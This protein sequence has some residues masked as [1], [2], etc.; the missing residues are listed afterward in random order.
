MEKAVLDRV[1]DGKHAVLL[2]GDDEREVMIPCHQLPPGAKK[3]TWFKVTFH[4]GNITYLEIDE[5]E[6]EKVEERIKAKLANLQQKK[7]SHFKKN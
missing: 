6:T 4:D 5:T 2:V 3:G 1:V 7:K